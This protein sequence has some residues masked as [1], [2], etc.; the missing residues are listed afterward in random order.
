MKVALHIVEARRE[1]LAALLKKH[2]YLSVTEVCRRLKVSEATARRDLASLKQEKK[3]TRTHGGALVD[4]DDRFPSFSQRR[5]AQTA[6]KRKIGRL[7]A[8]LLKPGG[9]YYL[10]CGTTVYALATALSESPRV[11]VT[12]VTCSLPVGELLAEVPGVNTYLLG[13]QLLHRQSL[14]GGEV[15]QRNLAAWKFDVAFLSAEAMDRHGIWNSNPVIVALQK[16]VLE[17]SSRHAFCID[18]SKLGRHAPHFLLPWKELSLLV[19]D[20]G[21]NELSSAGVSLKDRQRLAPRS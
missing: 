9:T 8:A 12:I 15:A 7:A 1:Q 2:R 13:G 20:A 18:R 16:T 21:A 6:G 17:R 4:F 14:L 19:S 5:N 10:D 11:P 3:I